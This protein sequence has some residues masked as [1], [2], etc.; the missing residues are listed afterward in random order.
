MKYEEHDEVVEHTFYIAP[1]GKIIRLECTLAEF[2]DIISV[3]YFI[4]EKYLRNKGI[5][6]DNPTD[7]LF[8]LGYI[9]F[10]SNI[11]NYRIKDAPTQAQI[12]ML[13]ELGYNYITDSNKNVHYF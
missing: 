6:T 13:S 7:V 9:A 10:G 8:K 5:K 1:D 11:Y 4:A 3:H 2:E 12:N